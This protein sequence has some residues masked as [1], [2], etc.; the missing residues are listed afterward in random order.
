MRTASST[1]P[2]A[3]RRAADMLIAAIVARLG[4]TRELVCGHERLEEGAVHE[5]RKN[6]KKIRA[7]L[8]LL[9]DAGDVNVRQPNALCRDVGRLLSGLRDTDVC[10]LT[11]E[12][13]RSRGIGA[14]EELA[15][16]LR[17]RREELH[18]AGAPDAEAE[19]Q[20]IADLIGVERMLEDL[21]PARITEAG[22][23][24]AIDLSMRLGVRRYRALTTARDAEALHDLRKAA[25]RELYQRRFLADDEQAPD[26]R[27][28]MLDRLGGHLGLHQDLIVLRHLAGK[29]D[30]LSDELD[31]AIEEQIAAERRASLDSADQVYGSLR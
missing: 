26:E 29:L 3:T 18:E 27:I 2:A 17:A 12:T 19:K 23:S 4:E 1:S 14:A 31:A 5:A 28:E 24:R 13:L 9:R 25:K 16:R 22:L 8:R 7:G 11:L 10:L 21:D 15:A 30:A 20:I 6:L